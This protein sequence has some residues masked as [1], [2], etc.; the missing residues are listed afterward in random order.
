MGKKKCTA[1]L[2]GRINYARTNCMAGA[3]R[4]GATYFFLGEAPG[5]VEDRNGEPFIGRAGQLLKATI[6]KA[7]IALGDCYFSNVTRCRP[8]N[9]RT[10][11]PKEYS[12]CINK[13]LPE[14]IAKV[15]P[16]VIVPVGA[17]ALKG[18]LS[19]KYLDGG[20]TGHRGR[21]I[22]QGGL[23]IFPTYHPA[24]A[25][26]DESKLPIFEKDIKNLARLA[27]DGFKGKG[28][29][30]RLYVVDT[31]K[32]ASEYRDVIR[33][34]SKS[35][36]LFYDVETDGERNGRVFCLAISDGKRIFWID[37]RVKW[38][39]K[40]HVK[41]LKALL[42]KSKET[43]AH[44]GNND[45]QWM[46]D[47]FGIKVKTT[48]DTSVAMYCLHQDRAESRGQGF[49][50]K[51]L[52]LEFTDFGDY[53]RDVN[54]FLKSHR[55]VSV[56]GERKV[57]PC[58]PKKE[59]TKQGE[60]ILTKKLTK[61]LHMA[62]IPKELLMPYNCTDVEATICVHKILNKQLKEDERLYKLFRKLMM[63]GQAALRRVGNVGILL[64]LQR[65][66]KLRES[67]GTKINTLADKILGM[68]IVHKFARVKKRRVN[69]TRKKP[70]DTV[71]V[72]LKSTHDVREILFDKKFFGLTP[73]KLSEK[74][75]APSCDK[76][77]INA[78]LEK[79]LGIGAKNFL[80]RMK[81]LRKIEKLYS[82]YAVG[83]GNQVSADGRIRGRYSNISTGTGR[84]SSF[85]PN[86]QNIPTKG[87][88]RKCFI[89]RPGYVLLEGDYSQIELRIAG[90]LSKDRRFISLFKKGVDVHKSTAS[91]MFRVALSEV[92]D[93]QRF[94]G[95][96]GN[97]AAIY[98]A[99]AALLVQLFD[100][101][102]NEAEVLINRFFK[103]HKEF[104]EFVVECHVFARANGYITTPFGRFRRLPDIQSNTKGKR[105]HALRQAVN[106][107]IQ[108]TASDILIKVL[109]PLVLR[110]GRKA[111]Y[112]VIGT[113]HDSILMEVK[114]TRLREVAKKIKATMESVKLP[115]PSYGI[116]ILAD[117]KVGKSWG[118]LK[119]YK[120]E[121][122]A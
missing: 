47:T 41:L 92:T 84:L 20:I 51:K 117:L 83:M 101:S 61:A 59:H 53:E 45:D 39:R 65:L 115:I 87:E 30:K 118:T 74:T 79:R 9:N 97:F 25:L 43:V 37:T 104:A 93:D 42:E 27:K 111:G 17:T 67:L 40:S 71:P 52:A 73:I 80:L 29:A 3:G 116:P 122:A 2:L 18:I 31:S 110:S 62:L 63:P 89:A 8:E 12:T 90:M 75:Q 38:W 44:Y 64:D 50:L 77:V 1:C 55:L 82:T 100:V 21:L 35:S 49:G 32:S 94:K 114:K 7:G 120:L 6:K 78:L 48:F 81:K 102:Y 33:S 72:L 58:V 19:V 14:E 88:F 34:L 56:D 109:V 13:W 16:K 15:K 95:K 57:V 36:V 60:T 22:E 112:Y 24:Y 119:K 98:G 10:P 113:V 108:G 26:R 4:V 85:D 70:L 121:E 107:P 68:K 11:T 54:E 91:L 106:T 23:R 86:M 69:A 96:T 66:H 103:G 28:K 105:Q 99:G 46:R 5:D 76:E